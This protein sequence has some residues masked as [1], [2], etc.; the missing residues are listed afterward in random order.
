MHTTNYLLISISINNINDLA[1]QLL[2][3]IS[4]S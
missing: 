4:I 3:A 1:E 2:I